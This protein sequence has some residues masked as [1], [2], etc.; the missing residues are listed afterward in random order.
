MNKNI[1]QIHQLTE[2]MVQLAIQMKN[3]AES[4]KKEY[5]ELANE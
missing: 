2:Q 4:E 3:I 1:K 5:Q